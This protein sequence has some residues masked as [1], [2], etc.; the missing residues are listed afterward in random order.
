MRNRYFRNDGGPPITD[1]P[2]CT[3]QVDNRLGSGP[4]RRR[5]AHQHDRWRFPQHLV[6]E[7]SW[8]IQPTTFAARLAHGQNRPIV[9][10]E[11]DIAHQEAPVDCSRQ[12]RPGTL[13]IDV[14]IG[15]LGR[16]QQFRKPGQQYIDAKKRPID[17]GLGSINRSGDPLSM[18][19]DGLSPA[20]RDQ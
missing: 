12:Q 17:L 7:A 15:A 14:A 6:H 2:K 13:E 3:P 5:P 18:L 19:S 8:E 16:P 11:R 1:E 20:G 4:A 10:Y 9:C